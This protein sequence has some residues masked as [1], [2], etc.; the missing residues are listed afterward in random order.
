MENVIHEK[1]YDE[2]SLRELWYEVMER[3]SLSCLVL[4]GI[5]LRLY[6]ACE[7][8]LTEENLTCC[9]KKKVEKK[10]V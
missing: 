2:D 8:E 10:G 6:D 7:K 5:L 9:M 3:G 4:N 1:N